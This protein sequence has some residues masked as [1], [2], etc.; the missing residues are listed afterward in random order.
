MLWYKSWL[1]TR[2]RFL[3]SLLGMAGLCGLRV[4]YGDRD[5]LPHTTLAY[6][7]NVL[8]SAHVLLCFMWVMA[9]T[10][11][12]MGG[13]VRE[14]AV[15]TAPFTLA[16]PVS[17]ARLM[18]VRIAV[19]LGEA[20]ALIVVP[21]AVMFLIGSITGKTRSPQQALFYMALLAGGGTVFLGTAL[22]TSSLVE[23]EYTAP[24]V[25][26]SAVF[27]ISVVLS[28][29][30]LHIYSPMEFIVGAEFVDRYTRLLTG[31]IPWLRIGISALVGALLAGLATKSVQSRDF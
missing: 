9:V 4:Y 22:L 17:R 7:Y 25:T 31:S 16:L 5:A 12:A 11:L 29:G 20:M 23:G 19:V 2:S 30:S 3:I 28:G 21:W 6:Y 8:Y 14:K 13:L 26:F 27:G 18:A 10:L 15:G 1:E 24:V